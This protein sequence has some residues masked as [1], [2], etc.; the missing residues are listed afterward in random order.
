M[1]P[2]FS[3]A[4]FSLK[5][6]GTYSKPFRTMY[7]WH[8]VKLLN[9][10]PPGSYEESTSYLESRINQ[11]YLNSLSRKT[12]VARLKK[13]YKFKINKIAFNWFI[14]NTDTLIIQGLKKYIPAEI[15]DGIISSFNNKALSNAEFAEYIEKRGTMIITRDPAIFIKTLLD[16][17]T[18]D[19]LITYENSVLEKKYPEFRYLMN[20]FHDGILLFDISNKKVWD[21]IN[22]DSAGLHRYYEDNKYNYLSKK[23]IEAKVYTLKVVN[24]EKALASAYKKFAGRSDGDKYMNEKFNNKNDTV[25]V[26]K[27]GIWTTGDDP[28]IDRVEWVTGSS[29]F[30]RNGFPSIILI[31]KV[32]EPLPLKFEEVE[33]KMMTGYQEY[34]DNE[35]IRQLKEKYNVKID[36]LVL[37]EV[38]RKLNN[39]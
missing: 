28:D 35:W 34:L 6:T 23:Q 2:D 11:S 29:S 24:G 3:E 18:S 1:I 22:H 9:R 19:Q 15:P 32:K 30:T 10:K 26:I 36:S 38:K 37:E 13:E 16:A 21:R 20:E 4:A 12:F 14:E 27:D 33:E 17:L 31:K 5:D 7:G 8:I 39:E 25:L